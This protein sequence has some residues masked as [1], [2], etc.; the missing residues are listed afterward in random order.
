MAAVIVR[1]SRHLRLVDLAALLDRDLS[2]LSQGARR[3][4]KI[5]RNPQHP[6][7]THLSSL[8]PI[9]ICFHGYFYRSHTLSLP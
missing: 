2:G 6:K 3:L 4:E 9:S 7:Y 1:E 8:T 5:G